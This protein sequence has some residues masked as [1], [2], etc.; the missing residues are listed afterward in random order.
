MSSARELLAAG[1]QQQRAGNLA[2]AVELYEQSLVADPAS[3]EAWYLLGRAR[4]AQCQV[5]EA[6][7]A[8]REALRRAPD[9]I[10]VVTHLANLLK[11]Q[12]EQDES[13]A[14]YQRAIALDPNF[15]GGYFNLG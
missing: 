11:D 9:A 1:R 2:A 12:G 10:E 6:I 13:A 15:A 4:Q 7:S 3:A 5:R 8:F 14:L